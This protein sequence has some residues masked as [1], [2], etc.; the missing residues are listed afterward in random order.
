MITGNGSL[1]K[2]G[3]GNLVLDAANATFSGVV[4]PK[5]GKL[6]VRNKDAL[7]TGT[8]KPFADGI[9]RI[10]TVDGVTLTPA[11]PFDASGSGVLNVELAAFD[12]PSSGKIE[13]NVFTLSNATAFD[14]S[15]V[16]IVAPALGSRYKIE[17]ATK[18]TA[19]GL[20]VYATATPRG[21]TILFR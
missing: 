20:V 8:I 5:E 4:Q 7:G 12:A 19:A 17:V 10:E 13:A 3:D 18:A 6:V 14:T 11:E 21:M 15:S 2:S 9:L 1:R 16:Q